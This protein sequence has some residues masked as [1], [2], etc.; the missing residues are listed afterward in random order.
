MAKIPVRRAVR[1]IRQSPMGG[2]RTAIRRFHRALSA[3]G[4]RSLLNT[5]WGLRFAALF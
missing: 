1:S 3:D 5:V 4:A 2:G